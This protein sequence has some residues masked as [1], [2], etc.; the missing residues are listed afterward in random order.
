MSAIEVITEDLKTH[1]E[2]PHGPTIL[3]SK[4]VDGEKKN[5]FACSACRDRKHCSFFVY[6]NDVDKISD[7]KKEVWEQERKKF[8]KNINHRKLYEKFTQVQTVQRNKS[9]YC[10]TC[11]TFDF[12]AGK[13]MGHNFITNLT[14]YQLTH[15]SEILPP[16]DDAKKEAQFLFAQ[17]S[18]EILVDILQK[19]NYKNVLCIGTP[20]I[21]EYIQ[22]NWKNMDSLDS[23]LLDIDDRYHN[24]YSTLKFCWYNSFNHH[25][26]FK[27]AQN[28]YNE[29]M[30]RDNVVLITD[31][32]F[33]G[34][35]EP[36]AQT[37][38]TIR[39][40]WKKGDLSMF[41]I[42]PYF[43]EPQIKNSLPNFS[44]LDY[45]VEYDNHPLF[46]S[47]PKGRKYGSP[48]RIFTNV[49]PK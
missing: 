36:L 24:F 17:S 16:L 41:W 49:S 13:H 33:G 46:Q 23:L 25:F 14:D 21:H 34:R 12:S 26:F 3:F 4:F 38:T 11:N 29:F 45:K 7:I 28:V 20:R 31:P 37:F 10:H 30:Q 1:P 27:E 18:V 6:Q 47:G 48:V 5:F 8:L 32:P 19:L 40:Q 2:C 35:I 22:S 15:P 44:M 42:F 43:M 9:I 39:K